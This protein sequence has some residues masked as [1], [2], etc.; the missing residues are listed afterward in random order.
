MLNELNA[1]AR[2]I[3]SYVIT[4]HAHEVDIKTG[5]QLTIRLGLRA[6]LSLDAARVRSALARLGVPQLS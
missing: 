3:N 5:L 4:I 2:S 1:R 6:L